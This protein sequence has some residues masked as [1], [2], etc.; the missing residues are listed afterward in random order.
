MTFGEAF[1][2]CKTYKTWRGAV[3]LCQAAGGLPI[4]TAVVAIS[5]TSFAAVAIIRP[6]TSYLARSLVER[7]F[8]VTDGSVPQLRN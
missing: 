4:L 2:N 1:P 8:V 5:P 6:E 3:L 7:G